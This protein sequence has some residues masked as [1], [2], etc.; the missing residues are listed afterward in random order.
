[1]TKYTE[2]LKTLREMDELQMTNLM[3]D[4]D[5]IT[6]VKQLRDCAL[7]NLEN[8]TPETFEVTGEDEKNDWESIDDLQR[9]RDIKSS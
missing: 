2:L 9:Y 1:M 3:D 5:D 8:R 7:H 4:L 6:V